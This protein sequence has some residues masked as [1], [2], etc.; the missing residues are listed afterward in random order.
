MVGAAAAAATHTSTSSSGGGGGAGL[1]SLG[2]RASGQLDSYVTPNTLQASLTQVKDSMLMELDLLRSQVRSLSDQN[3]AF[4]FRIKQLEE[5]VTQQK[6][7]MGLLHRTVATLQQQMASIQGSSGPAPAQTPPAVAP[8]PAAAAAAA[9]AAGAGDGVAPST[10]VEVQQ[11]AL[12]S[13][14]GGNSAVDA[15]APGSGQRARGTFWSAY[16]Q[17]P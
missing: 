1:A 8:T 5:Y 2:S 7:E 4:V 15:T 16:G 14:G 13:D 11:A 10:P 12:S 6:D 9:A 17:G 3:Q